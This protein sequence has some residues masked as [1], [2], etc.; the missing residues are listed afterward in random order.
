VIDHPILG[1]S[2]DVRNCVIELEEVETQ[3]GF[4]FGEKVEWGNLFYVLCLARKRFGSIQL[5]GIKVA[6]VVWCVNDI[7]YRLILNMPMR[8]ILAEESKCR[9]WV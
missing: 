2:L 3:I 8:G 4:G 5:D 1:R 6:R 7:F 9:T